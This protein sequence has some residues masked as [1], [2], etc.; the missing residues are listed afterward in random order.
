[1]LGFGKGQ[2]IVLEE[3]LERGDRLLF[4]DTDKTFRQS[5]P[6]AASI[7]RAT[8]SFP[9]LVDSRISFPRHMNRYQ[10]VLLRL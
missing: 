9:C 8:L 5:G 1:M 2:K 3:V 4:A 6:M 7:F 10:Y